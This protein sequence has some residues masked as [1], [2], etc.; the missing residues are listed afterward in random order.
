ML[1]ALQ[2]SFG[3]PK[4]CSA[5]LENSL[6]GPS[7]QPV[8]HKIIAQLTEPRERLLEASSLHGPREKLLPWQGPGRTPVPRMGAS[9]RNKRERATN[10]A[11]RTPRAGLNMLAELPPP[12]KSVWAA[13]NPAAQNRTWGYLIS[14]TSTTRCLTS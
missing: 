4:W 1:V 5:T 6:W 13:R 8:D 12:R 7:P 3:S 9:L 10:N 2:G 14:A 11:L